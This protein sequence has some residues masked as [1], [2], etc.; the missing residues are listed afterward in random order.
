MR[1]TKRLATLMSV[2]VAVFMEEGLKSIEARVV[3]S[4]KSSPVD[5][6][7]GKGIHRTCFSDSLCQ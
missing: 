4:R 1:S 3:L 7:T 2:L 5:S 6:N